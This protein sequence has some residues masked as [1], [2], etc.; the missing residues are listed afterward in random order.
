MNIRFLLLTI[1][2]TIN[3][4]CSYGQIIH[5]ESFAVILDT[6]K[7]IKGGIVPDFKFQNLKEDL[8]EFENTA[9]ISFK[10]GK[11]SVTVANR[12]V[13]SKYGKNVL[14]SGGFLYIEY[15]KVLESKFVLEPFSQFHWSEARGMKFKYAGGSNLRY[16]IYLSDELGFYAGTGLFYEFERWNYD[17]VQDILIPTDQKDVVSENIKLGT[18]MSFKWK[19]GFKLDFDVSLYHQSK[20]DK[21]F[22]SPRLASSFSIKYKFTDNLGLILQYQNIYDYKPIVP[23]D[24]LYNRILFSIDVSF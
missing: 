7:I 20:L 2:F 11:S 24:K 3:I 6:S 14:L 15:R 22:I 4:I 21:L 13:L 1:L 19:T 18:Y 9:D 23:I 8:I 16:R 5:T 17:G 12:I 10:I